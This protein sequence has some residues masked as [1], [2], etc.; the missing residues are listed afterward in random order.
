MSNNKQTGGSRGGKGYYI[1]LILCAAAIGITSYV[2]QRNTDTSEEVLLQESEVIPVGTMTAEEDILVIA[3]QPPAE[4]APADP[5]QASTQPTA[6]QARKVCA[7]VAGQEI[8]GYSME[9]LRYNQTTRDWRVHNGVDF[10]AEEGTPV[11]AAA[12]GT[13]YTTY[14]D[15]SMGHTVVIRH[16]GGYTTKYSSLSEAL[17]VSAGDTVE[18]GQTIGYVGSTALV[19]TTLGSHVHFSVTCQDVPM[20]PAEFL[21]LGE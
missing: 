6:K 3:T 7:P 1:A 21:S 18:A 8:F 10:G 2:Y 11:C 13:V 19:E 15:D 14:E 20:D 16:E 17:A 12:D 5:T 9:A 4:S